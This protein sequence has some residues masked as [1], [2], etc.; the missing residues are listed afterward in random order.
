MK[1][2]FLSGLLISLVGCA[3]TPSNP[4]PPELIY[5]PQQSIPKNQHASIT[6]TE[7]S[8][9][10]WGLDKQTAYLLNIDGKVVERGRKGWHQ[11]FDLSAGQ[12]E[13]LVKFEFGQYDFQQKVQF[14]A[15]AQ[16]EY[17]VNFASNFGS[18][19]S[20]N[21]KLDLWIE[22]VATGEKVSQPIN[23]LNNV[24]SVATPLYVPV[25]ITK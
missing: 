25:I 2:Y 4:I 15:E 20:N 24:S 13:V 23:S 6:G 7:R 16:H 9:K 22:D 19:F 17:R 10:G 3:A 5:A 12:H 18:W 14:E 11:V 8:S 21:S 1:R